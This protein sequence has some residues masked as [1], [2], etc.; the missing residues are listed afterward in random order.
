MEEP[1][2]ARRPFICP[3][4]GKSFSTRQTEHVH[5]DMVHK[6]LCSFD[7]PSC[8]KASPS[9]RHLQRHINSVH[10]KSDP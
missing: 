8:D 3:D 1:V 4:C 2:V 5:I 7:C 6:K 9:K 10:K